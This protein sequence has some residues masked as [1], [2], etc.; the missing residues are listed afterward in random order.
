MKKSERDNDA[1]IGHRGFKSCKQMT[2]ERTKK[3]KISG[4]RG[5][6]VKKKNGR[7]RERKMD[8]NEWEEIMKCS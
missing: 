4:K 2:K 1:H 7:K 3:K 8:R 6:C 5:K